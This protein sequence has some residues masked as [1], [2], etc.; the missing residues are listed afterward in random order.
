[1][2][3][4][5]ISRKFSIIL[6]LKTLAFAG[7]STTDFFYY[8]YSKKEFGWTFH[9]TVQIPVLD[10]ANSQRWF[11]LQLHTG[12]LQGLSYSTLSNGKGVIA[13]ISRSK[14]I[15]YITSN[16]EIG[17]IFDGET[18]APIF[19]NGSCLEMLASD[20]IGHMYLADPCNKKLIQISLNINDPRQRTWSSIPLDYIPAGIAAI[21]DGSTHALITISQDAKARVYS[22]DLTLLSIIQTPLTNTNI[23][24]V[25]SDG[26]LD[27]LG[28]PVLWIYGRD[29]KFFIDEIHIDLAQA[30]VFSR[31]VNLKIPTSAHV[32]EG[33]SPLNVWHDFIPFT[34]GQDQVRI[35]AVNL[36]QLHVFSSDGN[37]IESPMG[38]P[39][40]A[41]FCNPNC[42][43]DPAS[44]LIG[45]LQIASQNNS[46]NWRTNQQVIV[47]DNFNYSNHGIH[48]L[49]WSPDGYSDYYALDVQTRD[50]ASSSEQATKLYIQIQN[51]S[52]V[53]QLA[54]AKIRF[55]VSREENPKGIINADLYYSQVESTNLLVGCHE[56]NPN[57]CWV[58]VVFSDYWTL[59]PMQNIGETGLQLG[60]H[61]SDW[62]PWN[63]SNDW[64]SL[65][66]SSIFASNSRVSVYTDRSRT[67]EWTLAWGTECTPS[68][69]PPPLGFIPGTSDNPPVD[70]GPSLIQGFEVANG[71]AS[72]NA[73]WSV[74][75]SI[76]IDG[77]A[78]AAILNPNWTVLTSQPFSLEGAFSKIAF[79]VMQ[80]KP[81][82]NPYWLGQVQL[83]ISIPSK[84]IINAW[85]GQMPLVD[86]PDGVWMDFNQ[87][88][89]ANISAAIMS[90]VSDI[91]VSISL[92]APNAS[93]VFHIDNLR[94]LP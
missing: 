42:T 7:F 11:G 66:V 26:K 37:W 84:N 65:G 32:P 79:Q 76:F 9:R 60:V 47:S 15:E 93:G 21:G 45:Y 36:G 39:T 31:K 67:G 56:N 8:R 94:F 73:P 92:N 71:W 5:Q 63:K 64:S 25:K 88:L 68:D 90:G 70:N 30:I 38:T 14:R 6:M 40:P 24:K 12:S 57:L 34:I 58:D 33:F 22:P 49:D 4:S 85:I 54:N 20:D 55:W 23:L 82:V 35:V 80:P 87:S 77:V 18:E 46:K 72:S 53:K 78:S 27:A 59:D 50:V 61:Y 74:D 91:S 52:A 51:Q 17:F 44:P 19:E 28:R 41:N 43:Q 62:K 81:P 2:N 13:G 1:M 83:S 3:F 16:Q 75:H 69:V 86:K 29:E 48:R 10:I 89:P